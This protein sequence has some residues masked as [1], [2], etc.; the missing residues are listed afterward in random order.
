MLPNVTIR[1]QRLASALT[2]AL[3]P[4]VIFTALFALVAF[5]GRC[6][7]GPALPGG[8]VDSRGGSRRIRALYAAALPRRGLRSPPAPNVSRPPCFC[9]RPSW[10]FSRSWYCS[11]PPGSL[12][13]DP[14]DGPCECGGRRDHIALESE[15][16]LYRRRTRR[17]CRAPAARP[18]WPRIPPRAPARTLVAGDP[19]GAHLISDA[20]WRGGGS[21][22][23]GTPSGV[24]TARFSAG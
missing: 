9:S 10:H 2:N 19:Q 3:N 6:L 4:F 15:R 8:G 7:Q 23:C 12:F 22:V 5:G 18:F 20:R 1:P 24:E 14:F 13:A 21:R 17:R 11:M 16:P